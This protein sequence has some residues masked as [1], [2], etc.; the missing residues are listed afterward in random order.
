MRISAASEQVP[1]QFNA[2]CSTN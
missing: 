2:V 1:L